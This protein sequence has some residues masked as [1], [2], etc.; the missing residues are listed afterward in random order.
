MAVKMVRLV[1]L[2]RMVLVISSFSDARR[3][4]LHRLHRP[5][6]R[7][8]GRMIHMFQLAGQTIQPVSTIPTDLNGFA[9]ESA[10]LVHGLNTQRQRSGLDFQRTDRMVLVVPRATRA[11]KETPA[12][13]VRMVLTDLVL[14]W[15]SGAPQRT[16]SQPISR[17]LRLNEPQTIMY[18]LAG[19]TIRLASTIPT[20]LSGLRSAPDL[21]ALG[22]SSASRRC[23]LDFRWMVRLVKPVLMVLAIAGVALGV[24]QPHM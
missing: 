17:R 11:I 22:Q 23:G 14:K 24:Q 19:L 12:P 7:H 21:L 16:P 2:V 9:C 5:R 18:Q 20:D 4:T 6:L 15:F 8:N 3:L 10:L 13:L 1:L